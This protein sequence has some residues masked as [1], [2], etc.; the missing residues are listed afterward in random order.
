MM[1]KVFRNKI[2]DMLEVY[3]DDTIVKSR[4]DTDHA[5]HL[6]KVFAQAR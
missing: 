2:K 4:A 1:E 5:A 3:M 6:I